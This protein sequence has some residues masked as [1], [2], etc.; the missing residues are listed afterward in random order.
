MQ[1]IFRAAPSFRGV[2]ASIDNGAIAKVAAEIFLKKD[3]REDVVFM[4]LS[5]L[6]RIK[7]PN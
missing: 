4:E 5:L 1:R 3:R 6:L 2:E 7:L